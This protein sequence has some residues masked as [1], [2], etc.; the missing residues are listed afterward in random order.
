MIVGFLF[1]VSLFVALDIESFNR[2]FDVFVWI[3]L[4]AAVGVVVLYRR[5]SAAASSEA[6]SPEARVYTLKKKVKTENL[7]WKQK[8]VGTWAKIERKNFYEV[9]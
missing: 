4:L 3:Y 7:S 2:F 8:F 1:A 6:E 5:T 9:C